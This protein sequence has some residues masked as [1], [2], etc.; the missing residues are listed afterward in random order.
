MANYTTNRGENSHEFQP[1]RRRMRSSRD[2]DRDPHSRETFQKIEEKY[3]ITV[4]LSENARHICGA[5]IAA[6]SVTNIDSR[7][8]ASQITGGDCA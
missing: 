7:E 4:T 3:R 1:G 8:T 5:D 2:Q 6:A